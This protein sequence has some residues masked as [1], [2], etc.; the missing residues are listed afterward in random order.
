MKLLAEDTDGDYFE[1]YVLGAA[2]GDGW[3]YRAFYGEGNGDGNGDGDGGNSDLSDYR[4]ERR[5]T[6]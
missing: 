2:H 6:I 4:T 3:S 1:R 5:S